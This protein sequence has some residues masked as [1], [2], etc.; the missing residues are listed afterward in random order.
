MLTGKY[1]KNTQFS[2]WRSRGIL[3][4]FSGVE[5]KKNIEKV[6]RLKEVAEK[7]NETC[8]RLAIKWLINQPVTASALV[9]VKNEKQ[10]IENCKRID[11]LLEAKYLDKIN[12]IFETNQ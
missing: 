7:T 8:A 12:E 9:G 6:N 4:Q 2:D 1:D 11:Y 5:Y 10:V 3:G